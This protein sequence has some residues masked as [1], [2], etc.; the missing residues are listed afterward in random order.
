MNRLGWL[1]Y[2]ADTM[3]ARKRPRSARY[4][5]S[6]TLTGDLR[7]QLTRGNISRG[8]TVKRNRIV[9]AETGSSEV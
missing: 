3:P 1:V 6:C 8:G 2:G 7:S 4:V 5:R 9:V